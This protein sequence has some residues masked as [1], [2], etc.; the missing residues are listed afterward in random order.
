MFLYNPNDVVE[1]VQEQGLLDEFDASKYWFEF[2]V[3]GRV[4][5]GKISFLHFG[6]NE[7]CKLIDRME[8]EYKD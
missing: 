4:Q 5:D 7:L 3:V 2:P 1:W 8:E 6:Y